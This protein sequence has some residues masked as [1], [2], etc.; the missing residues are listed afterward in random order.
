[1]TFCNDCGSQI[2]NPSKTQKICKECK[3]K[4]LSEGCK[5]R[6]LIRLVLKLEV[7]HDSDN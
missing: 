7:K 6:D 2:E 4:R 1:M 5:S 3:S